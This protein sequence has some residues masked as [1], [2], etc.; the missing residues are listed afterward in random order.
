MLLPNSPIILMLIFLQE[1]FSFMI[2]VAFT[3]NYIMG[4]GFL[5]LPWAFHQTG[6]LLGSVTLAG[7]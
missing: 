5:T 6:I 4:T 2:A 1:G 3:L 7:L